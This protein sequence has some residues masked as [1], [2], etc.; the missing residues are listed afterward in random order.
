MD[1]S[2]LPLGFWPFVVFTILKMLGIFTLYMVGVAYTTL[3]ERKISAWIRTVT[4]PTASGPGAC[5]RCWP[6][7]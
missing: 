7:A 5:S 2:Q 6:T 1:Q 4:V 3:A